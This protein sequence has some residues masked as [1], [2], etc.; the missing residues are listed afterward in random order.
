MSAH[1]D[2]SDEALFEECL[3]LPDV[4]GDDDARWE[5]IG[6]LSVRR[7][8]RSIFE[9]AL[10]LAASTT[11]SRS[12]VGIDVLNDFGPGA[13]FPWR[14]ETTDV[15]VSALNSESDAVVRSAIAA[16]GKFGPVSALQTVVHLAG[17]RDERVRLS[18]AQ[19]FP[20]FVR[21]LDLDDSSAAVRALVLL[22]ADSEDI[23]R[24][25]AT[26]GL[27]VQTDIDSADVRAALVARLEDHDANT[28]H[29]ALVALARRH[30]RRAVPALVRALNA[31]EVAYLAIEAAELLGA[32]E[33]ADCLKRL[34]EDDLWTDE[35]LAAAIRRC[36]VDAQRR[37]VAKLTDFMDLAE[38]RGIGLSCFSV[39]LPVDS[40]GPQIAL[41]DALPDGAAW[42]FEE[43][44][45]RAS[46]SIESAVGL[47]A[48]DIA[49]RVAVDNRMEDA[50]VTRV[51]RHT[52]GSS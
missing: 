31:E 5:I 30:D 15:L 8:T 23:V 16:L 32:P 38:G 18:V 6:E 12:L 45:E 25:W 50:T 27:G 2:R 24:D 3:R 4:E 39:R 41:S 9:R 7:A 29:E 44:L 34:A 40:G 42:S 36:D 26:F 28:R 11:A 22:T 19:A 48:R 1:A 47:I 52:K 20:G 17:H 14:D 37:A 10:D 46:G 43:L 13:N 21:R 51:E 49:R 33:A 35:E